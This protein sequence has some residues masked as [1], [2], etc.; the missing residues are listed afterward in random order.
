MRSHL[1][2]QLRD[3]H[4][5]ETVSLCGWIHRR[6]DHGGV[7]FLDLRDFTGI[8]QVV[9]DPD[10]VE[11]FALADQVRNEFVIQ[12]EGRVRARDDDAINPKM[13]TGMVEVLGKELTILNESETPP[14]QLDEHSSAGEDVRLRNRALDLRRP[15]MQEKLRLRSRVNHLVRNYLEAKNFVD[16]ETPILTKATP[17]GARDYLVPSRVHPGNFYALPQSPQIFKQ[18]LMMSGFDRYYQIARCFRDEDLRADRQPEFTQIDIEMSFVDQQEVMDLAES[19]IRMLFTEVL[20]TDLGEMPVLTHEDAMARFGSDRPDLRFGLEFVDVGDL[21]KEVEFKVF[22]GPANDDKSR[23][24][25][26]R[27]PHGDRLTRKNLDDYTKFVSIYGAR[28]LAYIRVNDLASGMEGLQ[29]PILK[30]LPEDVV[31]S[32]L[33]RCGA[34]VG[35]VIFFG[36]DQASIVNDAIGALRNKLAED[37]DLYER[38]WASCWVVDFP[39]F[40]ENDDGSMTAVH[41]PFTSPTGTT[42]EVI[43]DPLSSLSQSYDLVINGHEVGGGSIRI[44]DPEMQQA[45]FRVLQMSDNE[46]SIKFGFLLDALKYGTPPHGGL[47]FGMD[48]IIMLLSGV[49]AIR[50]VIA[51]PKTQTATCLLTSAPSEIDAEQ[52]K[53][54]G[55]SV[56]VKKEK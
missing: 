8:V 19:L 20:G 10:T 50:D 1:C 54:L 48:R 37:L 51:F 6:R 36:A 44:H 55:I 43:A 16:I 17:E 4:I 42:A 27:L 32:I 35:D 47:A 53:E 31:N 52:L 13:D 5:G 38:E 9:F 46:A 34:E 21:L 15:E 12:V 30:F 39:M 23:V 41:H 14:F 24:V 56:S 18:L 2:G 25:A 11:S 45:I 22:S 7:I 33:K 29:S 40:E 28:G 26:L 3:T 49:N